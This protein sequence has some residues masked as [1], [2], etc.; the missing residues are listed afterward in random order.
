MAVLATI[1]GHGDGI[2]GRNGVAV[3]EPA[4]L[5]FTT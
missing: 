1:S 3:L 4:L 5:R 2:P